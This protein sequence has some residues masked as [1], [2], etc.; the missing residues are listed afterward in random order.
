MCQYGSGKRKLEKKVFELNQLNVPIGVTY[1]IKGNRLN[2]L[3]D[4]R[5]TEVIDR[6]KEEILESPEW[7]DKEEYTSQLSCSDDLT[8]ACTI[9]ITKYNTNNTMTII[10]YFYYFMIA[11]KNWYQNFNSRFTRDHDPRVTKVIE[12]HPRVARR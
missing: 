3:G 12:D 10:L 7:V 4:P 8:I 2:V 6:Y 5:I 9:N 11:W 1:S